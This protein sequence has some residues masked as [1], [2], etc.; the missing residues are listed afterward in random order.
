MYIGSISPDVTDEELQGYLEQFGTL[1]E[2]RVF[3]KNCYGFAQYQHHS[4]AV[5]AI[6]G[7]PAATAALPYPSPTP[8]PCLMSSAL[9]HSR[10]CV[11]KRLGCLAA[12]PARTSM[13]LC[14]A[15]PLY[16]STQCLCRCFRQLWGPVKSGAC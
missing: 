1:L 13:L 3:R 12:L 5:M 2:M 9:P 4:D 8:F 14:V 7:V 11:R 6:V 10:A 15:P 16:G